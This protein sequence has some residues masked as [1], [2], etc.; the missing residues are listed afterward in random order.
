M[1]KHQ[2]DGRLDQAMGKVKEVAGKTVGNE[3]LEGE[4]L[5]DQVKGKAQA[6]YGDAKQTVKDE[7]KKLINRI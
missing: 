2:V 6:G 1:N 7:A 3:H 5:A 4:G